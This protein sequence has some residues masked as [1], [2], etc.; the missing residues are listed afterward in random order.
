MPALEETVA[1]Q[2]HLDHMRELLELSTRSI[3]TL[4]AGL[5]NGGK[6]GN[7]ND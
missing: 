4:S 2:V 6:N 5:D 3:K 7:N 1:A